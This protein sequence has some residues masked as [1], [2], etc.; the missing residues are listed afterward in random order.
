[1][2]IVQ[3]QQSVLVL[4]GHFGNGKQFKREC[5]RVKHQFTV[6]IAYS[7]PNRADFPHACSGGQRQRKEQKKRGGLS[8]KFPNSGSGGM[9]SSLAITHLQPGDGAHGVTRPTF[10]TVKSVQG[11]AASP[12]SQFAE[13]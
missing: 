5:V 2:H 13:W 10:R 11:F 8:G 1:M 12:P 3:T 6:E 7:Q 4:A 9:G